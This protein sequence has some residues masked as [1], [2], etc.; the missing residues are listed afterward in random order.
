MPSSLRMTSPCGEKIRL[1]KAFR[2]CSFICSFKSARWPAESPS[3]ISTGCFSR[4][5][6]ARWLFPEPTPPINA[7]TGTLGRAFFK[8][9]WVNLEER[10]RVSVWALRIGMTHTRLRLTP[11]MMYT[12]FL[13]RKG[14]TE[15][16]KPPG[17]TR[18]ASSMSNGSQ[19]SCQAVAEFVRIPFVVFSL[20]PRGLSLK[21]FCNLITCPHQSRTRG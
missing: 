8:R 6:R 7:I 9:K 4:N 20:T 17:G 10:G 5:L 1:P 12:P 16:P 21:T 13:F 3:T 14:K 11:Y 15:N 18:K 19:P 2:K